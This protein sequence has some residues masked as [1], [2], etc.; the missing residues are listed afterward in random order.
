MSAHTTSAADRQLPAGYAD[1]AR[2]AFAP[3]ELGYC[4]PDDGAVLLR[5][6]S[7]AELARYAK[8]FDG[9]WPYL[10]AIADAAGISDPLDADVVT[11]YW[12]GGGLLSAVDPDDL[13]SR[14][15]SA[16]AGQATGLLNELKPG[17]ALAH[18]SFHVFAVYPWVRFLGG[19]PTKPVQVMQDCRIRWGSVRSV[20]D[21]HAVLSARPL[22]FADGVLV[23][24]D[25][26]EDRVRWRR[27]GASLAPEPIVGQ[28]ISAHWNW[29]CGALSADETTAL[30]VA[31]SRALD[32][33]NAARA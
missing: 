5:G 11:N 9:A 22:T 24:G 1:F 28:T 16:F 32:L 21:D 29:A 2:Y 14:L 30:A 18:H 33:I 27:D 23:L 13:L 20:D 12:I 17:Q 7:P 6:G 3:N 4:G 8:D 10:E 15:R 26:A 19:D 31:T 25:P